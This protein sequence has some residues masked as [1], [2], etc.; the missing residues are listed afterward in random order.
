[1]KNIISIILTILIFISALIGIALYSLDVIIIEVNTDSDVVSVEDA[2]GNI[3]EF[4]GIDNW[5]VDDTCTLI[6]FNHF[7]EKIFDDIIIKVF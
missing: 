2:T 7:T 1:M 6:M 4:Y 5:S 3:W